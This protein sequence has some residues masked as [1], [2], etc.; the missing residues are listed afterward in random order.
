MFR[1]LVG[2]IRTLPRH[3]IRMAGLL[4]SLQFSMILHE[5]PTA[6]HLRAVEFC[7]LIAQLI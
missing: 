5:D 7:S 3:R 1:P 4:P 6:V 2:A